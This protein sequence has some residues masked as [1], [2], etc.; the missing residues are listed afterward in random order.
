QKDAVAS[1]E[2][3]VEPRSAAI[4]WRL[5]DA[6]LVFAGILAAARRPGALCRCL[7]FDTTA[8]EIGALGDDSEKS[9]QRLLDIERRKRVADDGDE[10][11]EA[12]R[13]IPVLLEALVDEMLEPVLH[14]SEG[15]DDDECRQD[16]R[17][18]RIGA[19]RG[20]RYP[21]H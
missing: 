15:G 17:G 14:R 8:R 7:K 13:R 20:L 11:F 4:E 6:R 12:G 2:S 3:M 1:G 9:A 18:V 5:H 16:D 21:L 10:C 19:G